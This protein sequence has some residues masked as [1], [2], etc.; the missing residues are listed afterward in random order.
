MKTKIVRT[1]AMTVAAVSLL[2]FSAFA[3]DYNT[4]NQSGTANRILDG[5]E[6][7]GAATVLKGGED[8]ITATNQL[9][10]PSKIE[11]TYS[12]DGTSATDKQTV[13]TGTINYNYN[14]YNVK[15][16]ATYH[17]YWKVSATNTDWRAET[18]YITLVPNDPTLTKA[19]TAKTLTYTGGAQQL[20]N[21]GTATNG[22]LEYKLNNG[23]WSTN[24]PTATDAGEY[25]V[26]YKV[27]GNANYNNIGVASVKATIKEPTP[28]SAW[29]AKIDDYGEGSDRASAWNVMLMPGDTAIESINVKVN[30]KPSKEGEW[31]DSVFS[32][33]GIITFSVAVNAAAEN[34]TSV[35]AVVNGEDI[36]T[37][38][39]EVE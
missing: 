38:L 21:A 5:T 9:V 26:Y 32:G 15:I 17:V 1:L 20:V 30:G 37:T 8:R 24:I 12:Y 39:V 2:S 11:V 28:A 34:I 13:R 10:C 14:P 23:S 16:K 18:R 31:K 19:P 27:T 25:T 29:Y 6:G 22:K 3:K 33:A 35:T 36:A 7:E 4:A